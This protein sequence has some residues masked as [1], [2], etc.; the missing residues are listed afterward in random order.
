MKTTEELRTILEQE[1]LSLK[2]PTEPA[3]LYAPIEYILSLGGKRMRPILLL[4]AQQM[5]SSDT[6]K[7]AIMPA[8]ALEV[9]HNFTLLHD[10]IMDQA[11][12]RRGQITVHNKWNQNVAILSGDAML[13]QSYQ[14]LCHLPQDKLI[15]CLNV[16]NTMALQVCE[17]Q[18]YD[19]DFEIQAEVDLSSYLK[20]IEYKTAVLLGAALKMG[21]IIGGASKK[22]TEQLYEFGRNIGIAFQIKDDLLDVFGDTNKFGKQ[23]GGD[24][25]ANKKTCLYLKAVS[26]SDGEK[27]MDLVNLYSSETINPTE[28]VENVKHLYE[29]LE[30]EQH[31]N[32]LINEFY[33]K[34]MLHLNTIQKDTTEL[35]QFASQLKTRVS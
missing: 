4:L 29:T 16:F 6:T 5:Y 30:I 10:D 1:L 25:I 14:Y 12:V 24:I 11:P 23:L 15:E 28:K 8:I 35:K 18:Q 13:I 22:D 21:A 3:D 2:Y 9:F 34:A 26:L 31:I 32:E 33:D 20:M 19:M 27:K 17:G 7:E